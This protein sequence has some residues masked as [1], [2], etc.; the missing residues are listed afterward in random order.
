MLLLS[1]RINARSELIIGEPFLLLAHVGLLRIVA[2]F[3]SLGRR[4]RLALFH[5]A[6][7]LSQ[8]LSVR[9]QESFIFDVLLVQAG[10]LLVKV[11]VSVR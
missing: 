9:G 2:A 4:I 7:H 10:G 6:E 5:A 1:D 8:L 3:R 11:L